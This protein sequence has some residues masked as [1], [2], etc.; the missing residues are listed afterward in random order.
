MFKQSVLWVA[1]FFLVLF[2][3]LCDL[4]YQQM[5]TLHRDVTL[6]MDKY[7]R[8]LP[9]EP[10]AAK[11]ALFIVLKQDPYNHAALW[12]LAQLYFNHGDWQQAKPL[13]IRVASD[14]PINLQP[15]AKQML[16]AMNSYVP[17]FAYQA[18]MENLNKESPILIQHFSSPTSR[19]LTAGS[20]ALAK[21]VNPAVKPRQVANHVYTLKASGYAALAADKSTLAL[22]YFTRAYQ[23]TQAPEIAMQLGYLYDKAKNKPMAYHYFQQA[24]HSSDRKQALCA[25]QALTNLA[26]LQ[27]KALPEPYYS[28]TFFTPFSESRFGLTVRPLLIRLG[29]AQNDRLNTRQYLLMRRTDDNKSK[30]LGQISQIYEDD[31]QIMGVGTQF[32]P[33]PGIPMVT[34]AEAGEAYDLVYRARN[35]WR[36]DLRV[37]TMY[38]NQWG[39]LPSYYDK[40]WFSHAYFSDFYADVTYFSR[41]NNN[42]IGGV[43]THQ[44]IRFFQYHSSMIN[45]YLTGRV[46]VDTKRLFY[47]NFAEIGPGI[48]WIPTNRFNF[49][50]RF[51]HLNGAYLPAGAIANPYG[52]YYTNNLV[53]LLFYVKI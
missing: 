41:Y 18:M 14:G 13:L 15:Q 30:N 44:G 51:E 17:Y 49:Q 4:A 37:G 52:Q 25:E 46:I 31:V 1:I 26:E 16:A 3:I 19:G 22:D 29:M 12:Q 33:L 53:Q 34:Y 20:S 43:R 5:K 6:L 48:A 36:G 50:L 40:A 9:T 42:V 32:S 27:T 39:T 23:L 45:L 10:A 7:Y 8:L 47:N 35:R 21:S 28:E 2:F 38:Y 24:T 11:R